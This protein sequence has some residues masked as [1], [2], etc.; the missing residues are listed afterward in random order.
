MRAWMLGMAIGIGLVAWLPRL[1]P[2]WL[3]GAIAICALIASLCCRRYLRTYQTAAR[4]SLALSIGVLWGIGYGHFICRELLPLELEQQSLL[5]TGRIDGLVERSSGWRAQPQQR[6]QLRVEQCA[7]IPAGACGVDLQRVQLTAYDTELQP[8]GGERWQLRVKLK[9]PRG[10]ANPS[11]F[12]YEAWLVAQRIG[13]V[14]YVERDVDNRRLDDAPFYSV[15]RWR[16]VLQRY[17]DVRLA[18]LTHRDL[19]EGLL[20]GDGSAIEQRAWTMFRATG[21]VHLFVVSGLQIAFT[22]GLALWFSRLW[23]RSPWGRNRRRDYWLGVLPALMIATLYALLAGFGLPIQRALIMFA[24]FVG[25]LALR[26]EIGFDAWLLALWLVLLSNPLAVLDVGFWFSFIAVAV[27]LVCLHGVRSAR[28]DRWPWLHGQ[29]WRVQCALFVSSLP[30]MLALTGQF[31]LLALPANVIAVP[32]STFA[33]MP[34]AFIA[35][36]LDAFSSCVGSSVGSSWGGAWWRWADTSLQWLWLYLQ[37][38]QRWGS[39][40]IWQPAGVG[41]FALVCATLCALLLLLPRGTPGRSWALVFLLPLGW[42]PLEPIAIGDC[43]ITVIDVGQGLSVLVQTRTHNLLYD[44]GPLF[45]PER[46]AAELTVVPLLRSLGITALDGVVI[47]HKDSDHAGGWPTIAAQFAVGRLLVGE[48]L[49]KKLVVDKKLQ[50]AGKPIGVQSIVETQ[51]RD[52][53]R[54][55]WDGVEFAILHPHADEFATGNNRSCVLQINAGGAQIL[56]PG[57]IERVAEE[58]LLARQTLS[59]LEL[60][61]APHHGSRSSSSLALVEQLRPHYV[62]FS[63]GYRNRFKHPSREVVERYQ[64]HGAQLFDTAT[65]GALTFTIRE[66]RVVQVEE[67]RLHTSHYWQF[68]S[69]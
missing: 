38:L 39:A 42:P 68:T 44:A 7:R 20:I 34:L 60:L 4:F 9:R 6:W 45:G 66:G 11:G 33:T 65:S 52:D 3:A 18:T 17:L 69:Q 8:S 37:W 62:V 13:A 26:R 41:V 21:T 43:K 46:S 12:D 31:T 59:P 10:F 16:S 54:W 25:A 40:A 36:L 35:L 32:W 2:W 49:E 5:L 15:A 30:L 57:D 56:L 58:A 67:Q 50:S 28:V 1:P 29:W 64:Q 47:S 53:Q 14:G 51:C 24:C 48:S 22:G 23:W 63:A 27:I 61:L 19:L 55:Q